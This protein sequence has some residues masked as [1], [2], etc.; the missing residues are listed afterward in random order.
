MPQF[1]KQLSSDQLSGRLV[2]EAIVSDP[3][4]QGVSVHTAEGLGVKNATATIVAT[5]ACL[6]QQ[7]LNVPVALP[8]G[9]GLM[10]LLLGSGSYRST[11][12]ARGDGTAKGLPAFLRL[13][14]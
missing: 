5:P 13:H 6:I 12:N 8:T 3:K 14:T 11:G 4:C 9:A 10:R 7:T 2:D 1:L